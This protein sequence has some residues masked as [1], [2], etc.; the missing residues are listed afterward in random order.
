[1]HDGLVLECPEALAGKTASLAQ[2]TMEGAAALPVPLTVD[3]DQGR[4]W[5]QAK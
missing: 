4:N 5:A 1:M 3:V 2:A